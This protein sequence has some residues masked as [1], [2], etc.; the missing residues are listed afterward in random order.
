MKKVI[1]LDATSK[2]ENDLIGL[3]S[4]KSHDEF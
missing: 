1:T 2:K 4:T 3:Y